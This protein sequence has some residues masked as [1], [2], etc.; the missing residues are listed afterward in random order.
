MKN[1]KSYSDF[2]NEEI[3]WKNI[4]GYIVGASLLS[5]TAYSQLNSTKLTTDSDKIVATKKIQDYSNEYDSTKNLVS[6][7]KNLIG[8]ELYLRKDIQN[9]TPFLKEFDPSPSQ[10]ERIDKWGWNIIDIGNIVS[11]PI[12]VYAEKID[13]VEDIYIQQMNS[14]EQQQLSGSYFKILDLLDGF[15]KLKNIKDEQIYY[16]PIPKDDEDQSRYLT[17][18]YKTD[19]TNFRFPFIVTGFYQKVK[20]YLKDSK[21]NI[22]GHKLLHR[23]RWDMEKDSYKDGVELTKGF[24]VSFSDK[25]GN[26]ISSQNMHLEDITPVGKEKN[27]LYKPEGEFSL[28]GN[29]SFIDLVIDEIDG[30][31][32]I[33]L[34]NNKKIKIGIEFEKVFGNLGKKDNNFMK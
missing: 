8:E 16:F 26:L 18:R 19:K 3:N 15:L 28:N 12:S 9:H 10:K 17:S 30:K 14:T 22:K 34:E 13:S 33:I 1:I 6:N 20:L 25:S 31:L 7:L 24:E 32:K 11:G 4:L 23:I 5:N 29:W 27:S 21:V 2:C